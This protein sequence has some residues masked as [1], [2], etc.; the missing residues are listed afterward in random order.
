[1]NA[2]EAYETGNKESKRNGIE[3]GV[4]LLKLG[5]LYWAKE[6]YSDAKRCYGEAIGMLDKERPDYEELSKR[7]TILDELV[8]HTDAIYLQDS[9]QVLASLPEA[10]RN[11][12]IDRV[13]EELKKKEEEEKRAAQEAEVEKQLQKQGSMGNRRPTPTPA[14]AGANKSGVWYFYNPMAVSQG[15]T[16]F[17]KLWGKRENTDDWQRSNRTV[18]NLNADETAADGT[19]TADS[20]ATEENVA[21]EELSK[22]KKKDK[23]DG[24]LDPAEDPHKR[25]YYLAQIPFTD[26]Q[27]VES[28]NIIKDA[29]FNSGVIFKDKLDN[30]RLSEKALRRLTSQYS[31]YEKN[32]ES[33]YHLWLLYSRMGRQDMADSCLAHMKTA[34]PESNWTILLSDPLFAE[35]AKFGVHIEDSHY[36]ATYDAF[37]EDRHEEIAANA[38]ISRERFP[39]GF[40]R[41]K[42]IFIEGLSKL[43]GGDSEGCVA[44]MTEVIEKY[45][46]NEISPI[47][48]MILKGVQAGRQLHGGKFD[49]DGIWEQRD[50]SLNDS[51]ATANDTLAIE[52]NTGYSFLLAYVADSINENQLRYEMAKYN[53]SNFMVRNFELTIDQLGGIRRMT[54]SGFLNY[55]EALQYARNLATDTAM[56]RKLAG[57]RRIVISDDNL[58]LLGTKYSYADYETFFERSLAPLPVSEEELLNSPTNIK[59]LDDVYEERLQ[60]QED[61]QDEGGMTDE[62]ST[63]ATD[64]DSTPATDDSGG[65]DNELGLP[66][67]DNTP[68]P[69][70]QGFD[71]DEDFYR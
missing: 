38:K 51:S 16:A 26:E 30:L 69:E 13:I 15:K 11:K 6:K 22:D 21:A 63:P 34:Y 36:A 41:A 23:D 43:N 8:P 58:K 20:L 12:A 66:P 27:K 39:L 9:L 67:I 57:C 46:D 50:L 19:M 45:P 47:A 32:D 18:V 35:N 55:D 10:E 40:N 59:T 31:E 54:I 64:E 44:G 14:G 7:S 49:I 25:E 2:I 24:E 61:E 33:W 42:F 52:R 70:P 29:L 37:K 71:F 53:F 17:Q 68:E 5:N 60:E 3:K 28:N 4:L 65:T 56:T 48:G 62:D 1:M